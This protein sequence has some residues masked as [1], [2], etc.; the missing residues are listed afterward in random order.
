MGERVA[1]GATTAYV[2]VELLARQRCFGGEQRRYRHS[3]AAL[4]GDAVFSLY[5]PPAALDGARV[6]VLYWLS[7]RGC[8]DE[9]FSVKSGAQ[10]VAASLGLALVIPDTSPRGA[11]VPTAETFGHGAS[12]YLDATEAPWSTHYQ[13]QRYV[14]AELPGLVESKFLIGPNRSIAG[15]SLGGHGALV[16]ALN[17]PGRYRSVSAFAPLCH[18]TASTRGQAI[19][20][21]LL[22][23]DTATWTPWDASQKVASASEQLPIRIDVGLEDEFYPD[24]L[25]IDALEQAAAAVGYPITIHRHAHYDHSYFFVASFIEEHLRFH[26]DALYAAG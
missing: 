7:G 26:Q 14:G 25:R 8:T 19:F 24:G 11:E 18:P 20:R 4:H 21:A 6:P 3:S 17:R 1:R 13:M 16:T 2:V 23:H 12:Y 22:G 9:N 5:L 15:H 10:R